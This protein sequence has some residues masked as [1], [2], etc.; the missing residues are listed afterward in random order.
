M[1]SKR[2]KI[3]VVLISL[4]EKYHIYVDPFIASARK[5][6][7]VNHD[8]DFILW[9]D[10]KNQH[11]AL[12]VPTENLGYPHATLLRYHLFL[13]QEE[14]LKEYDYVFYSD[15]DMKF[16]GDVKDDILT[17]NE[18]NPLSGILATEHPGYAFPKRPMPEIFFMPFEPNAKSN[19]Y[20]PIP[21][22]YFAGGFQGGKTEEYTKAMKWCRDSIDKDFEINYI[23]R[24][25][26]ESHW[27]KCLYTQFPPKK[28]LGVEYC[29]PDGAYKLY[30][31]IWGQCG[32]Y[33]E[34]NG[35]CKN[36]S[37]REDTH[38]M[39]PKLMCIT[40][41]HTLSSEGGAALSKLME[42]L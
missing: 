1:P 11:D 22:Y 40:K 19:A 23:A 5:H 9:T 36:C 2:F 21:R 31:T 26:D 41:P 32:K 29:F 33:E 12:V 10:D 34:E 24:W 20:F 7:L 30:K 15:V 3:A 39:K 35:L 18:G 8:V 14:K 6:F 4:G 42:I 16:I 37:K 13:Q 25:H 28:I 17:D 38:T 27:N